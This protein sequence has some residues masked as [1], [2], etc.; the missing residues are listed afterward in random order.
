M[1]FE[2]DVKAVFHKVVDRLH[3]PSEAEV[4]A[5]RDDIEAL[6]KDVHATVTDV[7]NAAGKMQPVGYVPPVPSPTEPVPADPDPLSGFSEADLQAELAKRT[8]G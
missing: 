1:S 7:E 6:G 2:N 3:L 4:L 8:Q 5:L